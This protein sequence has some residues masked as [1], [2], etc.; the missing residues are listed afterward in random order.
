M[1]MKNLRVLEKEDIKTIHIGSVPELL[2]IETLVQNRLSLKARFSNIP[3]EDN[4][5]WENKFVADYY[6]NTL[7]IFCPKRVCAN[8]STKG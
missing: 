4:N 6:L 5:Y 2:P 8:N 1:I 3:N 7:N